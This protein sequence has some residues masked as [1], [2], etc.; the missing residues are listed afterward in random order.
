VAPDAALAVHLAER[1]VEQ[2]ISRAGRVWARIGTD[3]RVEA[4]HGL[5]QVVLEPMVE[6][7]AGGLGEEV[8]NR[9]QVLIR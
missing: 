5:H 9:A 8:I 4:E 1:V 6:M 2:H 3:H 7:I